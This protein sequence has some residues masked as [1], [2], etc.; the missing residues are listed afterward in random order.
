MTSRYRHVDPNPLGT[1]R[2]TVARSREVNAVTER[3]TAWGERWALRGAYVHCLGCQ[4]G[5][6]HSVAKSFDH[7]E[8][9]TL[10]D[11]EQLDPWATL[12]AILG[13]LPAV[14]R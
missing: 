5:R 6:R 11:P 12:A 14:R 8:G 2:G 9:C 1:L 10:A 4:I 3:L 13:D 7:I